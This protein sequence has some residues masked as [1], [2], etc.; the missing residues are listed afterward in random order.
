MFRNLS[1]AALSM[2]VDLPTAVDLALRH[3]W[4]GIDIP[5]VETARLAEEQ[6][7]AYVATLLDS[8]RLRLGAWSLPFD[9]RNGYSQ[10]ALETL[11][12]QAALAQRL[13]CA[14]AYTWVPPASYE[15]PFRQNFER[16]IMLLRPIAQVLS[17]NG[18]RLGL[19]FVGPR[20][21]R[22]GRRYG[23]IYTLEGALCLAQAIGFTTGVLLDSYHW[24]TSLGTLADIRGLRLE[25]VVYVHVNDAPAGV[26]VDAQ[27]DQIRRLPGT[28]GVIDIAGFLQT[29]AEI[30]YNGP[31]TPEPFEERLKT[32]TP[33]DA[34][35]EAHAS[36]LEIWRRAGLPG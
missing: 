18:C 12:K 34:C 6:G 32:A 20:T 24:Y 17:A 28:T 26:A 22:D 2:R 11:G 3:A 4:Q 9:W 16:H 19:E 25:D 10:A 15:L 1:P 33:D 35:R 21:M 27:L 8:A 29:L 30:G 7:Y 14:R 13:G 36:M 31:V 23:F 5:L